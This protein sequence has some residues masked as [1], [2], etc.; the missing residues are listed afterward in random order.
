MFI[1]EISYGL[2]QTLKDVISTTG[3]TGD[4]SIK[5]IRGKMPLLPLYRGYITRNSADSRNLQ[6]LN[7]YGSI[8]SNGKY[9]WDRD[10]GYIYEVMED[11][12]DFW[13]IR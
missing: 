5:R 12:R 6:Y 8:A 4:W 3:L 7:G 2:D 11:S 9:A 1:E 10:R 13:I